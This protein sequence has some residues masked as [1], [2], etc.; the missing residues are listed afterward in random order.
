MTHNETRNHPKANSPAP[1]SVNLMNFSCA[2]GVGFLSFAFRWFW[3]PKLVGFSM[4]A[5]KNNKINQVVG[6]WRTSWD[7]FR[8]EI[9]LE[10]GLNSQFE[11]RRWVSFCKVFV[12]P[13]A[14]HTVLAINGPRTPTLLMFQIFFCYIYVLKGFHIPRPQAVPRVW[15]PLPGCEIDSV[16]MTEI[17]RNDEM[18]RNQWLQTIAAEIAVIASIIPPVQSHETWHCSVSFSGWRDDGMK[19]RHLLSQA[20]GRNKMFF[21]G[22]D[23]PTAQL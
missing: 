10:D 23:I 12:A 17:E 3:L 9:R 1:T 18:V 20:G 11:K 16:L 4:E 22:L 7:D 13:I 2:S 6:T 8:L 21:K 5:N 14:R 19:P 15:M